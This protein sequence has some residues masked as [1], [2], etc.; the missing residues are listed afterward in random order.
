MHDN[1]GM[2]YYDCIRRICISMTRALFQTN[3]RLD[4]V[5]RPMNYIELL[6]LMLHYVKTDLKSCVITLDSYFANGSN[7][8]GQYLRFLVEYSNR[9]VLVPDLLEAGCSETMVYGLTVICE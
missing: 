1:L 7:T 3:L 8:T 4:D 5:E 9:T 6:S 2:P